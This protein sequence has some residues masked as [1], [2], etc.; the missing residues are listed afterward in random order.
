MNGQPE[1]KIRLELRTATAGVWLILYQILVLVSL[2]FFF[3]SLQS[4][5]GVDYFGMLGIRFNL[6]QAYF[7]NHLTH[8]K[9]SDICC[10]LNDIYAHIS[11]S[12]MKIIIALTIKF[13]VKHK[14]LF[15]IILILYIYINS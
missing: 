3:C 6:G 15:F 1:F 2:F 11:H 5:I 14:N 10:L 12:H 9:V 4:G 13:N 8:L 7:D